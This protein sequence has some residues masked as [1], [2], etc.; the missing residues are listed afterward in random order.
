MAAGV[1]LA[2]ELGPAES[3]NPICNGL[4]VT[5]ELG[6]AV[7]PPL[8]LPD[9]TGNSGLLTGTAFLCDL[10][11]GGE[12]LAAAE[13]ACKLMTLSL[14]IRLP[15]TICLLLFAADCVL[16]TDGLVVVVPF[17]EVTLELLTL[18]LLLLLVVHTGTSS[19]PSERLSLSLSLV[20]GSARLAGVGMVALFCDGG[21]LFLLN[22]EE[23]A[24]FLDLMSL[25]KT[26]PIWW[27]PKQRMHIKS[28]LAHVPQVYSLCT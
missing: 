7:L 5:V 26:W 3:A 16:S 21:E 15:T 9:G 28:L 18:L 6:L 17:F 11:M 20:F 25:N 1:R 8:P 10:L 13:L 14:F 23:V 19:S 4:L 2:A 12:G 27:S 24:G 22:D